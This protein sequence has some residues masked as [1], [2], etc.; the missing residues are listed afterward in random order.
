ME[1]LCSLYRKKLCDS[2][3]PNCPFR[4][5]GEQ[6]LSLQSQTQ[7]ESERSTVPSFMTTVLPT[8]FIELM[9]HPSPASILKQRVLDLEGSC[10]ISWSFPKLEIPAE[11]SETGE[12]D[13]VP[14]LLNTSES[15]A[16]LSIMGWEPVCGK[17]SKL[18]HVFCPLCFAKREIIL[19]KAE[20][21]FG[22]DDSRPEKRQKTTQQFKPLEAHRH[23]CP[24]VCGFPERLSD[25]KLPIWKS[26]LS[27]LNA[28]HNESTTVDAEVSYDKIHKILL[29][30]IAPKIVDLSE[31][32]IQEDL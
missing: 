18:N 2:H 8:T 12:F 14:H 7:K 22:A 13:N 6:L 11:I 27:N 21:T 24:Y 30:A 26:L 20:G 5:E 23:Y 31:T 4:I 29:D 32:T 19:E 9:E 3:L 15:L 16:L 28:T 17:D 10:P 25:P 1:N